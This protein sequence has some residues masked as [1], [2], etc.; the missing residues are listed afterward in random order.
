M[1]KATEIPKKLSIVKEICLIIGVILV[2]CGL[3]MIYKPIAVIFAG[4]VMLYVG[5]PERRKQNGS[6][7]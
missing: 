2:I 5:L 7:K 3:W 1:K 4:A 6:D